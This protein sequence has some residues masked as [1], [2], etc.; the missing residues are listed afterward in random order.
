MILNS[1][2]IADKH[3]YNN[4]DQAENNR[5]TI[6]FE[7]RS[8]LFRILQNPFMGCLNASDSSG[9]TIDGNEITFDLAN[10]LTVVTNGCVRV[11]VTAFKGISILASLFLVLEVP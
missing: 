5:Q 6:E 4:T 10:T 9:V 11:P 7:S 2:V 8:H 1:H 3:G